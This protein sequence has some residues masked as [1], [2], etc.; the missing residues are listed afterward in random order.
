MGFEFSLLQ[1][2]C[3]AYNCTCTN[4]YFKEVNFIGLF[5]HDNISRNFG[6]LYPPCNF[7]FVWV[8]WEH[9]LWIKILNWCH[10]EYLVA[11]L[12]VSACQTYHMNFW[13]IQSTREYLLPIELPTL[14]NYLFYWGHIFNNWVVY[15][16]VVLS[17]WRND[18]SIKYEIK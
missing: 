9:Y 4:Q 3:H 8:C 16:Y 18:I 11:S 17:F 1:N 5:M 7:L 6:Y 10:Y 12:N 13:W 2:I 15:K 14:P